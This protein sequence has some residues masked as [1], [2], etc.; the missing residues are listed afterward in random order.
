MSLVELLLETSAADRDL[1]RKND[2]MG[3]R[4]AVARDVD[5]LLLAS[6]MDKASLVRDFINDNGYGNA[7]V[8]DAGDAYRVLVTVHMAPQEHVLCSV[9]GLMACICRLFGLDYDG[10]GCVIKNQA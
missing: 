7:T 10:W 2:S 3:D 6:E 4:F 1:M 9:S 8:E 5:F